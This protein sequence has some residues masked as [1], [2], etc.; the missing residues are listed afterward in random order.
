LDEE[1]KERLVDNRRAESNDLRDTMIAI[2]E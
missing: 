2:E 1:G